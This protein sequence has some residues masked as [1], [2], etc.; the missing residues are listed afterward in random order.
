LL[1]EAISS[2]VWLHKRPV[3]IGKEVMEAS[4]I[5]GT[6]TPS[7]ET[8]MEMEDVLLIKRLLGRGPVK[9]HLSLTNHIAKGYKYRT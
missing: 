3:K 5:S 6:I 4:N 7:P 8:Q 9:V 1:H 2:R